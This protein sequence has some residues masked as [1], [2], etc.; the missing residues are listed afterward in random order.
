MFCKN[1]G[2]KLPNK[3]VNFCSACGEHTPINAYKVTLKSVVTDLFINKTGTDNED[4]IHK[5]YML[6]NFIGFW[7]ILVLSLFRVLG[8]YANVLGCYA[9]SGDVEN[10]DIIL[11]FIWI[12]IPI[13]LSYMYDTYII[14][15]RYLQNCVDGI[16]SQD[17]LI[18]QSVKIKKQSKRSIIFAVYA[19]VLFLFVSFFYNT[20]S[21]ENV[22]IILAFLMVVSFFVVL[23]V[24]EGNDK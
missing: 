9:S 6:I 10:A 19:I 12:I 23:G 17:E 20:V 5:I 22:M 18:K 14:N 13:L 11:T 2:S 1:C 21:S 15:K 4:D 24:T 7:V 3:Y 8:L 16:T